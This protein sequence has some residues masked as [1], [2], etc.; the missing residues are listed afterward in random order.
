MSERVHGKRNIGRVKLYAL[1]TCIW[2]RKTKALLDRSGV[3]YEYVYVDELDAEEKEKAK[4]EVAKLAGK[5]SFPTVVIDG[6]VI[7]GF[8]ESELTE[9]LGL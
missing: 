3:E 2:C 8:R 5:V 7:V 1:S 4:E 6:A 9:A